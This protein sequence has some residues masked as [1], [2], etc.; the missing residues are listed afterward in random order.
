MFE[1]FLAEN[2]SDFRQRYEGTFGYYVD[3]D[4]GQRLLC[5][6]SS[7]DLDSSQRRVNFEDV[8]GVRF[9]V[10]VNAKGDIGFEF[11]PP[12]SAFYNTTDGV[13]YVERIAARQFQRGVSHRNTKIFRINKGAWLPCE[14]SFESLVPLL[15]KQIELQKAVQEWLNGDRV[16][17]ALTPSIT[18]NDNR[19][20]VLMQNIGKYD[21]KERTL[22]IDKDNGELFL[23]EIEHALKNAGLA[24]IV[25][26]QVE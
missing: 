20:Y 15:E 4:K 1:K 24:N 26:V 12:R 2:A 21:K 22:T 7:V 10:N 13:Y 6:L 19:L 14:V 9:S 3:R 11:I 5:R 18:L 23:S 8:R 25:K 16:S 17:V